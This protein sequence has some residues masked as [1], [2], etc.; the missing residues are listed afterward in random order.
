V[1]FFCSAF[2]CCVSLCVLCVPA[3]VLVSAGPLGLVGVGVV[4]GVCGVCGGKL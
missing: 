4:V 1:Q 3:G 2:L